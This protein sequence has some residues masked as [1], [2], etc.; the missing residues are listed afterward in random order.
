[1]PF[2]LKNATKQISIENNRL[3]P[4]L[5]QSIQRAS[6]APLP[7]CFDH[8]LVTL[9]H[10]PSDLKSEW[11]GALC[12]WETPHPKKEGV[13]VRVH[14]IE[15]FN[16]GFSKLQAPLQISKSPIELFGHLFVALSMV[17]SKLTPCCA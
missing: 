11:L 8:I 10:Y 17:P 16:K 1:M 13:V 12:L 2:S 5:C 3:L 4:Y 7:S 14:P 9:V 15:D 6:P